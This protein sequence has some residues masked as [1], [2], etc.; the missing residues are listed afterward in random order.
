[1]NAEVAPKVQSP[2]GRACN[3]EAK[4]AWMPE[5]W[6]VRVLHFGGVGATA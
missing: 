3:R 2:E 6:L 1:V 5:Y 4:T